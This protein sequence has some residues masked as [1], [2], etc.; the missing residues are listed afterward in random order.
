MSRP[1]CHFTTP[2]L[3]THLGSVHLGLGSGVEI[4]GPLTVRSVEVTCLL[5]NVVK[6]RGVCG[7]AR[8]WMTKGASVEICW[9]ESGI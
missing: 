4:G 7:L 9:R 5:W 2:Y 8:R 1:R 3:S 6:V